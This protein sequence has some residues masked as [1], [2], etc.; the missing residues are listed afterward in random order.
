[1]SKARR[2]LT[3][4]SKGELSP[5]VEG[6][7]DL[8]AYFEGGKEIKNFFLIR[9]GGLDRRP[10]TRFVKEVKDSSKDTISIPFEFSV[11]DAYDLE[12]GNLYIRFYKNGTPI[13]IGGTPVEIVSP[14]T[15]AQLRNI[16]FT[17][18]ADVLFLFHPDVPQ[19]KLSRIS[20]TSWVLSTTIYQPPPSFENDTD[21]SGGTITLTP[22]ATTGNNIIFTASAAVFLEADVGRQII[23]GAARAVIVAFGSSAGDTASPNDHVRADI[24]DVF[25][26]TNPIAAGSW[27]LRLSPQTTLNPN[28]KE[29]VG[30]QVTLV[31]GVNAFRTA[32]VGKFLFVYGG[33]VKITIRDSVI[34]VRGE[35]L[36]IMQDATQA[37]PPATPAG[38]WSLEEAS[39]SASQ[40]YARTGEFYGGRL[41]QAGTKGQPT[42]WWLSASD[43]FDNYA[44]GSLADDA[45]ENLIASRNINRIEWL[46]DNI[47]LFLG[48]AGSE[49]IATGGKEGEPIGGDVIP[50]VKKIT[51]N[52]CAPIQPV[53]ISRRIIFV[54]RSQRRILSISFSLDEDGFDALEITGPSEHITESGIRLGPMAYRRRLDPQIFFVREDGVLIVLTFYHHEKV[55]GFT[56]IVTDGAFESV[57]VIPKSKSSDQVW[58]VVK[59]IINGQTKRYIEY[60]DDNAA[61]FSDRQWSSLQT[62][63]AVIYNGAATTIIS[64]LNHLEGKIVDVVA[65]GSFRGTK[66][67][68][69]GSITLD[70][71]FSE[72][73][74]GLHYDSKV[75]TMRPA[76]E[77]SIIEGLPRSWDQIWARFYKTIG[78]KIN[79]E[80]IQYP[81]NPLNTLVPFTGDRDVTGYGWDDDGRITIEQTEPY[82]MTLL[83][84]FGDL[85]VSI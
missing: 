13:L 11:D 38:S 50:S 28:I 4:F 79:N 44:V 30:A 47:D 56:R 14:Y 39:W 40:G 37:D 80:K 20:D 9:Q 77:G 60:L 18:S 2:I 73:E 57:S 55:I 74:V 78:G 27:F 6:R 8:S 35:L 5:L 32:D 1:M 75:I 34:Q 24:L 49:F 61:E 85:T 15:E 26:D 83:A 69:S 81:P 3:N 51:T 62:D 63:S 71:S 33:L 31:S 68:S 46:A 7:P 16:H 23:S 70:E 21:V 43:D 52:G 22:G 58:V 41:A 82:P 10:G 66:I 36:S 84:V 54:D 67:V 17:Q 19:R 53:V 64:G 72:V 25:V 48:T 12:F 76:V 65:D 59:R 29:P 45:V 42:G